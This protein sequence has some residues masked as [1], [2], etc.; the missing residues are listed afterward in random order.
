[1]SSQPNHDTLESAEKMV[2]ETA[3]PSSRTAT[4][5]P[6]KRTPSNNNKVTPAKRDTPIRSTRGK[7][8]SHLEDFQVG[9]FDLRVVASSSSSTSTTPKKKKAASS[10]STPKKAATP[11]RKKEEIEEEEEA[12]LSDDDDGAM[13]DDDDD[14]DFEVKPKKSKQRKTNTTPGRAKKATSSAS[15]STPSRRGNG[16]SSTPSR[17]SSS[18][19]NT[20]HRPTN[21]SL[22]NL[23]SDDSAVLRSRTPGNRFSEFQSS[24]I[25]YE[26]ALRK[27]LAKTPGN[28]F[29]RGDVDATHWAISS[30]PITEMEYFDTNTLVNKKITLQQ[31]LSGCYYAEGNRRLKTSDEVPAVQICF[32]FDTTGSQINII[33]DLK[34][35]LQRMCE[36]LLNDIPTI[37][38]SII[39]F[40]DYADYNMFYVMQKLDF[41]NDID[42]IVSFV[43]SLRGTGG[44]DPAECYEMVLKEAQTLSWVPKD[45]PF[46]QRSLVVIGDDVPHT[47]EEYLKINYKEEA[48]KLFDE[49]FIKI[50][51]VQCQG[52]DYATDFYQFLADETGGRRFELKDFDSMQSMF[53]GLCYREAGEFQ[54]A[55]PS[56]QQ[57]LKSSSAIVRPGGSSSQDGDYAGDASD[58]SD[59]EMKQVHEAIHNPS[60]S[61]VTIKGVD[62]DISLNDG[63]CRFVRIGE[64]TFIEQ[65]KDKG[66]KYAKMAIEGKKI[67]WITRKGQ[68]GLIIDDEI[69]IR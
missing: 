26:E 45:N 30:L 6:K 65:N 35:K 16:S 49:Y 20:H 14:D 50:H 37:Q 46:T 55:N 40:G 18:S 47:T 67:T 51:S 66:T 69:K 60:A 64:G 41:S 59:E 25:D 13:V 10:S 36:Q 54:M 24:H 3:A 31:I 1:M 23:P 52:R 34:W 62:Y 56:M 22:N 15:S 39:A 28:E 9:D 21:I 48:T 4:G 32:A 63:A 44:L 29:K 58:L 53:L 33:E 17:A 8:P 43:Q 38:I 2:D 19:T 11:K 42:Q 57:H 12:E 7:L 5:T 68:W 61:K 27:L